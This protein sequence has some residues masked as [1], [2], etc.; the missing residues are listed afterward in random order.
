M[1]Y[2]WWADFVGWIMIVICLVCAFLPG[3]IMLIKEEGSFKEVKL[4]Y[5]IINIV[6]YILFTNSYNI[7]HDQYIDYDLIIQLIDEIHLAHIVLSGMV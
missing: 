4:K 5:I 3:L 2:P 1:P 6:I 7:E